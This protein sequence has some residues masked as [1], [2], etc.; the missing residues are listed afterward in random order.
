M[1]FPARSA[2]AVWGQL[3]GAWNL[4]A[5]GMQETTVQ[6]QGKRI[7]L[8]QF[9]L[10]VVQLACLLLV[11]RQFQ[12]E[13]QAFLQVASL[14][15]TGA[16][17][18]AI[19]PFPYRLPFFLLLSL[20]GIGF[21]FG[22]IDGIYII[23]LGLMIIAICHLPVAFRNRVALLLLIGAFLVLC[24]LEWIPTP[25]S[26]AIWPILSSMFMFRLIVY[27]YDLR[28]DTA[29]VSFWR[30]LS[31]FFLL[32][33]V[34][35]PLFPI[36]DYKTFRRNYYDDDPYF[37]YQVG[38]EWMARGL[39]QLIMYRF[40]YNHLVIAP[41]DVVDVSTFLRYIV[42]NFLLYLRVSGQFHI[43]IGMLHLFGFR[44]PETHHYYYLASSFTDFWRRINIYWKDFMLKIFFYP[45]YFKLRKWGSIQALVLSTLLVFFVTWL[46]HAYQWFWFRGSFLLTWPD[47]LFWAVLAFLVVINSLYEA[48]YSRA[49][50]MANT[51]KTLG[52]ALLFA[53]RT[54]GTFLTICIL[55]SLWS[56][57]SLAAWSTLWTSL[58]ET[59][60]G[61]GK[62]WEA[63]R[64]LFILALLVVFFI[65]TIIKG[66]GEKGQ[67]RSP[68]RKS[69]IMTLTPLLLVLLIGTPE[70][71][72]RLGTKASTMIYALRSGK[73]NWMEVDRLE[74]GYYE[75]LLAVDRFNSQLWEAYMH[76][77]LDWLA[78]QGVGL[79]RP[80]GDFLQRE[81]IPS[82]TSYA[83]RVTIRTNRWGMRDQDYEQKPSS[84]T[85]RIALLGASQAMGIGVE[86][87]ETFEG[88]V[89]D[90][91]NRQHTGT[92]YSKYEILNFAAVAYKPLQQ[93]M[94]TEKALTFLPNAVFY[95][96]PHNEA[97][98]AASYLIEVVH[99][100]VDIPYPYLKELLQRVGLNAHM[101][102]TTATKYLRPVQAEML[103][104]LYRQIVNA[105]RSRGV[106]PVY[107]YLPMPGQ[108]W[109]QE[110]IQAQLRQAE[111]AGFLIL[112][113][114]GVYGTHPVES[115]RL[116]DWDAH[117]NVKGHQ[118]IA[119]R[120]Y[121]AIWDNADTIFPRAVP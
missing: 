46:L 31:Y 50:R 88:L 93:L 13:N 103:S 12:L 61:S 102:E 10:M 110:K 3:A 44:L 35:F 43:I 108:D 89:E 96:A 16:L 114:E 18:H 77:P 38:M 4:R 36:V 55:W 90:R 75:E 33:N 56:S 87:N 60:Q 28:H 49:R 65:T 120:L 19:L 57:E 119:D 116:A 111:E 64:T 11:I 42:A 23:S 70:V 58:G 113:L 45:T 100:K 69:I 1:N 91:L 17:V 20:L 109:P 48:K 74:R 29:P 94:V 76:R 26:G 30:T 22:A 80:T 62:G 107:V 106:L 92:A 54:L 105:C 6:S 8:V 121:R 59:H 104:W 52:G 25:W 82:S 78:V 73:L 98:R 24:R 68:V 97:G 83:Y 32:P 27:L 112:H 37:I 51:A 84:G 63:P 66:S 14:A 53:L 101:E 117:P 39:I 34:C 67:Q 21:I 81:L 40:V 5:K 115:V 79:A 99:N 47:M 9:L 85:Y 86:D 118:L 72:T 71:Y 7:S 2:N 15:F 95:V 41:S